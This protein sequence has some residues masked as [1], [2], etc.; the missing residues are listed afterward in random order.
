LIAFISTCLD[1]GIKLLWKQGVY[2]ERIDLATRLHS[3]T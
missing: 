1:N 2:L 3:V